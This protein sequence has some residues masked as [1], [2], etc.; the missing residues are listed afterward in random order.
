MTANVIAFISTA[1][2]SIVV[3]IIIFIIVW[4]K[5]PM[6]RK[7]IALTFGIGIVSYL[8]FQW[9]IQDHAL[10][11]L[12]KNT[13]LGV[14]KSDHYMLYSLLVAIINSLL[15]VVPCFILVK[16][17]FK[18][19]VSYAKATMWGLGYAMAESTLLVGFRCIITT[20]YIL[21]GKIEEISVATGE[22]YLS[23]YERVLFLIINVAVFLGLIYLVQQK[24]VV[25]GFVI[26]LM[27][28]VLIRFVPDFL[29]AFSTVEFFETIDR[30]VALLLT[31]IVL[32]MTAI[33]GIMVLTAL[34]YSM[35]DASV[36]SKQAVHA[37]KK[38]IE[39]K[40]RKKATKKEKK[41]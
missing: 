10:S 24:M 34:K 29:M 37:Y 36:D 35:K 17:A 30:P 16:T 11:F 31:Y 40:T 28:C 12:L 27:V 2:M 41:S 38:K 15:V 39:E 14:W 5:N 1:F 32:T 23:V 33:T 3:P 25:R 19:Q 13:G 6:E 7:G 20:M 8:V 26:S 18:E 22:L 9:G 4:K 21:S